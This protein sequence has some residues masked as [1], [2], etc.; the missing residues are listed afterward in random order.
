[1]LITSSWVDHHGSRKLLTVLDSAKLH[2]LPLQAT[3]HNM[4]SHDTWLDLIL[5]SAP[6]PVFSHGQFPAPGF[7]DHDLI[8]MSYALKPP[9]LSS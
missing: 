6:S 4:D 5:T 9:K 7:T 1:M 2:V 8:Y 3:H